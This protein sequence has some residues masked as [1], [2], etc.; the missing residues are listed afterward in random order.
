MQLVQEIIEILS[1]DKPNL[2]NALIKAQVLAHQLGEAELGAW[3]EAELR[4][5]P[6]GAELPPYRVIPISVRGVITNGYYRHNDQAIPLAHLDKGLRDK[7]ETSRLPQSIA[8]IQHWADKENLSV[9]IAPELYPTLGKGLDGSY[10]VESAWGKHSVGAMFQV[11]TEVRS[12]LLEFALRISDQLPPD[13]KGTNMKDAS[14][15][16]GVSE[17]FRNAIFGDNTTIVVGSGSIHGVNNSIIH[18]DFE[19]LASA[20]RSQSV[21]D[22]DVEELR[23]AVES[24]SS[25][26]DVLEKRGFGTSV[27]AWM[28]R[29][30]AKAGTSGW[31]VTIG[32][33]GNILA[34][35][36]S[37]FYGFGA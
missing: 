28:G 25:D 15:G 30:I 10:W 14:Q 13:L 37:K 36:V 5:Y 33:A 35:A 7:L 31:Q 8:V 3:V 19:S 22:A 20:L 34:S 18:N 32:A 2:E 12:R 16:A 24:D 9:T 6:D 17:T 21:S 1:S 23:T 27:R 4:G 11:V 26:P 29:M